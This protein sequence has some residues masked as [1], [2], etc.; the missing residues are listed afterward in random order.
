MLRNTDWNPL[1]TQ[2]F[3]SRETEL[4]TVLTDKRYNDIWLLKGNNG[5]YDA[6]SRLTGCPISL[7]TTQEAYCNLL[8]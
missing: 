7:Y 8:L 1:H 6:Y 2:L 3:G 4:L 5:D